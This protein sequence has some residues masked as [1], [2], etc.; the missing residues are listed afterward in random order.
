VTVRLPLN[1]GEGLSRIS[2]EALN[3]SLFERWRSLA[4]DREIRASYLG[5]M[6][7]A[8]A[9]HPRL[10]TALLRWTQIGHDAGSP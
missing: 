3:G 10:R 5:E 9:R 2:G 4:G 1:P 8:R 6:R 7:C